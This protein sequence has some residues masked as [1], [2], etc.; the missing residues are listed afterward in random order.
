[1]AEETEVVE[2]PTE[3]D[4]IL[5]KK[6]IPERDYKSRDYKPYGG[7]FEDLCGHCNLYYDIVHKE[8]ASEFAFPPEC[9]GHILDEFKGLNKEDFATEEEYDD[10]LVTMDPVSWMY[11]N[12]G[13]EARWYQ[14]EMMSCTALKKIVR[15]GRRTGKT[16]CIAA[17]CC[18]LAQTNSN[19]TIL[20][21]A[22]YESQVMKVF[23]EI[24]KFLKS[25]P[26][27]ASSIRRSTKSPHHRIEFYNDSKIL[28]FSSGAQSSARS[29]KVRGQDANYIVLDE[30]DYLDASDVEAILAILASHPNCGLWASSTPTGEHKKFY[31]WA[32]KKDLGFKEFHY[33]SHE[34]PSWTEQAEKFFRLNYDAIMFEHEFLAEFGIQESGVFRNDLVDAS[35]IDAMLPID[36]EINTR[37]IMGV[38]WNGASIGTHIV[39]VE[40]RVDPHTGVKYWILEKKIIKGEQFTAHAAVEEIARLVR[41]YQIDF[42]YVDAGYGEVQVEMLR[43]LG[44]LDPANRLHRIVKPYAMQT[45]IEIKDPITGLMIKK[46]A[47]PFMVNCA[48]REL[49][50]RRLVLPASE[51]TQVLVE[52][53][54][55]QETGTSAGLVQQMR[56]F[57]IER[58]SSLGLPTYSQGDDHT[59]TAYMLAITGFLLEFSDMRRSNVDA[60]IR[61]VS[62]NRPD[63][64]NEFDRRASE[65]IRQLDAGSSMFGKGRTAGS[66]FKAIADRANFR[67]RI[68]KGDRK[69]L[70]RHFSRSN[71]NR[72]AGLKRDNLKGDDRSRKF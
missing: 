41:D 51:D 44:S 4:H 31:E 2:G 28:G 25:S 56:N 30:A 52:S 26:Q 59:L 60:R 45:K 43:K 17:L 3:A 53:T 29:D 40:A 42:V 58:V 13:W 6:Y 54:D 71:I 35:L 21:I 33:I 49:E 68:A 48:V 12:F 1:M 65:G 37:R 15:A 62:P 67:K 16:T 18:W 20:V 57:K 55:T 47:K 23:E 36:G 46:A 50:A 7:P 22:P 61:E 66:T 38:D 69:A 63:E 70:R 5:V 19:F 8:G 72:T 39:I 27:I 14:E 34:S 11:K 24:T 9:K 64:E 32:V 10:L